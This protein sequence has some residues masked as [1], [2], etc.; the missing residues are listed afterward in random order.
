MACAAKTVSQ[1]PIC[2][3]IC[4]CPTSPKKFS[5][6]TRICF[7]NSSQPQPGILLYMMSVHTGVV[8]THKVSPR[9]LEL[10][11]NVTNKHQGK[12]I[13]GVQCSTLW[14]RNVAKNVVV[15]T[16]SWA[17]S[18]AWVGDPVKEPTHV[19]SI[20]Q[21]SRPTKWASKSHSLQGSLALDGSL[22]HWC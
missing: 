6:A 1:P 18:T 17:Y 19:Q 2:T 8:N 14:C 9:C 21:I 10:C 3:S 5:K 20:S 15:T 22:W 7:C 4:W 12:N 11:H 16:P 13:T